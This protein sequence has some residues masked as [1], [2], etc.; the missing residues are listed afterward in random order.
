MCFVKFGMISLIRAQRRLS[1]RLQYHQLDMG[2]SRKHVRFKKG[3]WFKWDSPATGAYKLNIDGSAKDNIITGRGIIRDSP[4][5]M[6]A[7]F[8]TMYGNGTNTLAES[9]ALKEGLFMC[10]SLQL[11]CVRIESDSAV[12]VHAI[13]KA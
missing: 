2:V 3:G 6:I 5:R 11:P 8:S 7:S 12:M 9:S 1:P 13:K 4:G 10:S